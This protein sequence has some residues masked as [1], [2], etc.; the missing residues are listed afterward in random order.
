MPRRS[1][2]FGRARKLEMALV[3]PPARRV[4][5]GDDAPPIRAPRKEAMPFHALEFAFA[6]IDH[7]APVEAKLR[8]RRKSL[9]DQAARAADSVALNLAEGS[10]RIG[11]DRLDL[12][13]KAD[14]SARELTAAL[15]IALSR[16]YITAA[17]YAA[18]DAP[19]DR[20]RAILWRMTRG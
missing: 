1:W 11:L 6:A 18:V 9:A 19:L 14:G 3:T 5:W 12:F 15:R 13:R 20:V 17:D 2:M 7:L 8:R 16:G 10:S 4:A